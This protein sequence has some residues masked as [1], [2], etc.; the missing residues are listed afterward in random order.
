M[1]NIIIMS[2]SE[3]TIIPH[4]Y[5]NIFVPFTIKPGWITHFKINIFL[6]L[7]MTLWNF[8][9]FLL[10]VKS[11]CF[12]AYVAEL[13]FRSFPNSWQG[14]RLQKWSYSQQICSNIAPIQLPRLVQ[15]LVLYRKKFAAVYSPQPWRMYHLLDVHRPTWS[16]S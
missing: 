8:T 15:W 9:I 12:E 14:A 1:G 4:Q 5:A 6:L 3:P 2:S 13:C 10:F 11:L 7:Y 16:N